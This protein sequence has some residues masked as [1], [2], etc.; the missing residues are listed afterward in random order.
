MTTLS[1]A[2]FPK[3]TGP[4]QNDW[5]NSKLCNLSK[6]KPYLPYLNWVISFQLKNNAMTFSFDRAKTS[7]SLKSWTYY[8]T[9]QFYRHKHHLLA[10][11][12]WK[13]TEAAWKPLGQV[14]IKIPLADVIFNNSLIECYQMLY[15]KRLCCLHSFKNQRH[16]FNLH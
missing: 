8:C 9:R 7:L 5:A 11:S 10:H 2:A 16:C 3:D 4:F 14:D 1:D 15:I 6:A 12:I 13:Y